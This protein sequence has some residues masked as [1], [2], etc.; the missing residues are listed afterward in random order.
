L[1][2]AEPHFSHPAQDEARADASLFNVR[3]PPFF[4]RGPGRTW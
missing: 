3:C 1:R 4:D 2:P